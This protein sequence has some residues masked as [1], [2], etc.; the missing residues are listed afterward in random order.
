V[1]VLGTKT[2]RGTA[3]PAPAPRPP[4]V[5]LEPPPSIPQLAELLSA[6]RILV[7]DEPVLK[8]EV[9]N[10]L[11]NAALK[12]ADRGLVSEA[13]RKIWEREQQGST[14]FNEGVAFPHARMEGMDT[15][16]VALGLT[17]AGI[18][19]VATEKPVGVVF[20][21]LTPLSSPS[22]QLQVLALAS[23]AAQNRNLAQRFQSARTPEQAMQAVVAWSE[24]D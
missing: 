5:D 17:H 15:P 18:V 2:D 16:R 19:D 6:E 4:Q 11:T 23:R 10:A 3:E 1:V 22:E 13:S 21:L 12:H 20:L 8:D 9:L 24:Q 7:W 14:F